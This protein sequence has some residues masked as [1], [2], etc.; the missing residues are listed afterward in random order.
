MGADES[1]PQESSGIAERKP[2]RRRLDPERCELLLLDADLT[3]EETVID[4]LREKGFRL[5]ELTRGRILRAALYAAAHRCGMETAFHAILAEEESE[6]ESR[7]KR[8]DRSDEPKVK[9]RTRKAKS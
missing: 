2:R 4:R 9:P 1:A 8:Q 5:R 7:R 3:G 6:R